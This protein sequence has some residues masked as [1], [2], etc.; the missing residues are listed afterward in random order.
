MSLRKLKKTLH[1]HDWCI[2]FRFHFSILILKLE[3]V[4]H[5][6]DAIQIVNSILMNSRFI[7]TALFTVDNWHMQLQFVDSEGNDRVKSSYI[8][9]ME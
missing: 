8:L 7:N 6:N 2:F 4:E 5:F 9:Q 1:P 3:W